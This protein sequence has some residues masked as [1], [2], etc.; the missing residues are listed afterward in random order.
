MIK[1]E[2]PFRTTR[3]DGR[4]NTQVI[5]G[6][7]AGSDPGRVFC[8]EELAAALNVGATKQ[9]QTSDVQAAV[10]KAM[11][12]L[13]RL[14]KRTMHSVPGVGYRLAKADEHM[15]LAVCRQTKAARQLKRG[16]EI[17]RDTRLDE[18]KDPQ[19]R[20]AH[21]GHM[22]VTSA[23]LQQTMAMERRIGRVEAAITALRDG[24]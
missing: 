20:L 9:F 24:K 15:G 13:G 4:S 8:Y 1:Q 22:L 5:V 7:V 3:E 2:K 16:L 12:S 14:H 6:L 17:L 23:I 21:E 10:R 19:A 11:P 18:I